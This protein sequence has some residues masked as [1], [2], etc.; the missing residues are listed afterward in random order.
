M[1]Q[2]PSAAPCT[3]SPGSLSELESLQQ[4]Q[5]HIFRQ[6]ASFVRDDALV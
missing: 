1:P 6:I 5:H 3:E 2:S 4:A